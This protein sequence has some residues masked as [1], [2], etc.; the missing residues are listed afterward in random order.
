MIRALMLSLAAVFLAAPSP[1]PAAILIR[2]ARV[3]DGSGSPAEL[4]D[5]LVRGDRIA[6]VAR[7]IRKPADARLIDATGMTLLPG[8][9]DLHIHTRSQ[10]FASPEQLEQGYAPYLNAG[11]TS[12]NEYS[13]APAMLDGIRTM[14]AAGAQVPHLQLALRMGVPHGHGTESVF[15]NGITAQVTTPEQARTAV[16]PII[17]QRPDV[18]KV[19]TDG[20]R[21]GR[22]TDRPS[23]DLPTLT[24]IVDAAHRA[25]IPVVTHT[26][27]LAGAKIAARARVDAVV[28]G[29]GDAPVDAE[30][31]RLMK[32]GGTAYVP[33][34]VVYEPQQDRVFL[35]QEMPLM[36]PAATAREQA[37]SAAPPAPIPPYESRRWTIMQDNVR[38]LH[39]AG[40]RIGIGTDAGIG[41]VY[42]G[43]AT[44]RE[45]RWMTKLGLTPREAL[46]AATGDAA[47]IIGKARL[48]GRI[49]RGRRADLLLVAGRPDERI[50]DIYDLRAL[51]VAGRQ[52]RGTM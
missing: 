52:V 20:W 8:L 11:V 26:V 34:L 2:G 30:L 13:V 39:R 42:H 43:W 9:H 24:A 21:Y 1:E 50:E 40:V 32:R 25:R 51:F 33:T 18:I 44:L 37:R 12:V 23:M 49:T 4:R 16:A 22:D 3:F 38:L 19:F 17:G 5:V 29:V 10:A 35:P 41:G 28:H 31:I 45:I 48:Q 14:V 27:T 46:K 7:H 6:S 36:N 47:R 15:T